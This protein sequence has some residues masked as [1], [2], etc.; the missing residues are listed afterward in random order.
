M[1]HEIRMEPGTPDDVALLRRRDVLQRAGR[2]VAAGMLAPAV[3][4]AG[5]P[6]AEPEQQAAAAAG[7]PISDVMTRLTDYMSQA[8]NAALPDKVLEQA[9]WHVVDTIA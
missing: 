2:L 9:S 7:H 8:R 4:A 3:A 5:S 1:A 6:M